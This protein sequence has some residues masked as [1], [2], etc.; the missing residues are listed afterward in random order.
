MS[1]KNR[2][3][4]VAAFIF[5]VVLVVACGGP[6]PNNGPPQLPA[7]YY[8]GGS[9][10]S[11]QVAQSAG[12]HGRIPVWGCDRLTKKCGVDVGTGGQHMLSTYASGMTQVEGEIVPAT[13]FFQTQAPTDVVFSDV[14]ALGYE[15]EGPAYRDMS[16]A[17]HAAGLGLAAVITVVAW[18]NFSPREAQA[19]SATERAAWE[20]EVAGKAAAAMR[21]SDD[22]IATALKRPNEFKWTVAEWEKAGLVTNSEADDLVRVVNEGGQDQ[23]VRSILARSG[24]V[25][26]AAA[27]LAKVAPVAS[28]NPKLWIFDLSQQGRLTPGEIKELGD[29]AL[30]FGFT[31]MP[32]TYEWIRN[33]K[34]GFGPFKLDRSTREAG[35]FG[36]W[37]YFRQDGLSELRAIKESNE[38]ILAAAKRIEA[39]QAASKEVLDGISADLKVSLPELK[40]MMEH[41]VTE[42]KTTQRFLYDFAD[43]QTKQNDDLMDAIARLEEKSRQEVQSTSTT[44]ASQTTAVDDALIAALNGRQ[45]ADPALNGAI[46]KMPAADKERVKV[47]AQ[48]HKDL[49]FAQK[50]RADA[51][52]ARSRAIDGARTNAANTIANDARTPASIRV[53]VADETGTNLGSA[54]LKKKKPVLQPVKVSEWVGN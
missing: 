22:A 36:G 51:Q 46:A 3:A 32:N 50:A 17:G 43:A 42:A 21:I 54:V 16:W 4:I 19:L 48:S 27:N 31:H 7:P 5:V 24:R 41:S 8:Q 40:Q 18:K 47:L 9:I 35:S 1:K 23:A 10:A 28:K 6:E 15:T 26:P 25:P 12:L 13:N 38:A 53:G 33:F 52:V 39:N 34:I 11:E 49:T 29:G 14:W 2:A 30:M 37:Q 20:A 45:T 44:L